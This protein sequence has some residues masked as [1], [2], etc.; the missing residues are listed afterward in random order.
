MDY[1]PTEESLDRLRRSGWT[2]SETAVHVPGVGLV[3][4]VTGV[5]R[6]HKIRAEGRTAREAWF[7]AV[8]QAGAVGMLAGQPGRGCPR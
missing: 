8:E 3:W 7:R 1:P 5:N 4:V 6:E 2:I